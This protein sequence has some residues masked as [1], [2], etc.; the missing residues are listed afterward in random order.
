MRFKNPEHKKHEGE[1]RV[2]R[3]FAWLPTMLGNRETREYGDRVWLEWMY[4]EQVFVFY[5]PGYE[6][7]A[8]MGWQWRDVRRWQ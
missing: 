4:V 5:V 8:S 7:G 6:E 1:R 3:Q 2:V